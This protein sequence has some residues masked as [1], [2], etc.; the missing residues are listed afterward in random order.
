MRTNND[1]GIACIANITGK[2]YEEV[3]DIGWQGKFRGNDDDSFWH[4]QI[5]LHNLGYGYR[6][7]NQ[8]EFVHGKFTPGKAAL[9]MLANSADPLSY[10]WFAVMGLASQGILV[11]DGKS[12]SLVSIKF[13]RVLAGWGKLSTAYEITE[14]VQDMAW[15]KRLWYNITGAIKFRLWG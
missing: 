1:C 15:W 3:R 7:I 4:H 11:A 6:R 2:S 5:A 10:H 14:R 13:E 8:T 9:M 12:D